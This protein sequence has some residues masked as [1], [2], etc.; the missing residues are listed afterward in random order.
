MRPPH[1]KKIYCFSLLMIGTYY[2]YRLSVTMN[3]YVKKQKELNLTFHGQHSIKSRI[4]RSGCIILPHF[5][6]T[7]THSRFSMLEEKVKQTSFSPRVVLFFNVNVRT[8][9]PNHQIL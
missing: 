7:S 8:F 4:M 1:H 2:C 5:V 9:R 6:K 3:F